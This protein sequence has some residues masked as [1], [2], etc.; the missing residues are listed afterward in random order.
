M[1]FL[2]VVAIITLFFNNQLLLHSFLHC[3]FLLGCVNIL[4]RVCLWTSSFL[5]I[6]RTL[7][8]CFNSRFSLYRT[9]RYSILASILLLIVLSLINVSTVLGRNSALNPVNREYY[10]CIFGSQPS[11]A[12][13][14][15]DKILNSTY[16]HYGVPWLLHLLSTVLILH[17]IARHKMY[18]SCLTKSQWSSIF[19]QQVRNHKDFLIPPILMLLCTTPHILLLELKLDQCVQRDMKFYLKFH[20]VLD[21][22]IYL[23]QIVPFFIY[24]YPSRVYRTQYYQTYAYAVIN[25]ISSKVFCCR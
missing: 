18:V 15:V 11:P 13:K 20:L 3:R 14:M 25:W 22:F 21:I 6:E 16:L 10:I 1:C 24:I 5:A 12:W 4:L 7:I 19:L 9:R 17:H 23:P 2:E 8:E